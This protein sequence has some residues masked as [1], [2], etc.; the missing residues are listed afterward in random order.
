[1]AAIGLQI[2]EGWPAVDGVDVYGQGPYKFL[3]DT[4][5]H[6]ESSRQESGGEDRTAGDLSHHAPH[7]D[8]RHGGFRRIGNR[9]DTRTV[10]A[11]GQYFL[12]AGIEGIEQTWP[13]VKGV[14][15][16]EFLAHFD[17]LLDMRGRKSEFGQRECAKAP[18]IS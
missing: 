10:R 2:R 9:S 5:I 6:L 18:Q 8:G 7:V 1:M 12:F 11:A 13:D 17:Y 15:G 4:G 16:Q 14:L 3:V